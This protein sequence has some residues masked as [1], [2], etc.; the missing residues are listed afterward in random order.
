[1]VYVFEDSDAGPSGTL[2][3]ILDGIEAKLEAQPGERN[4]T[5]A[6]FPNNG[7]ATTL[8][9]IVSAVRIKSIETDE[10]ALGPQAVAVVGVEIQTVA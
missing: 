1:M 8:G 9:G 6:R 10:G 5:G 7:F 2:Q 3:T 4:P